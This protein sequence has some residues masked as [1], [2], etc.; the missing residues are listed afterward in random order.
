[1]YVP[2][3]SE[4]GIFKIRCHHAPKTPFMPM[5]SNSTNQAIPQ[6]SYNGSSKAHSMLPFVARRQTARAANRTPH[7]NLSTGNCVPPL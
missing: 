5:T 4:M 7:Q 2:F 3:Q 6:Q 1:M